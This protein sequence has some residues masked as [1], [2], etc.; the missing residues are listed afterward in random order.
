MSVLRFLIRVF[1][2]ISLAAAPLLAQEEGSGPF[3]AAERTP[4]DIAVGYTFLN[5]NVSGNPT[6]NLNG[7]GTSATINFHP[8][9]GATLDASYVRAGRDPGSG[10]SSYVL[11]VLTGPVFVATQ[12]DKT[13]VLVRVLGGVSVVDSAVRVND[14]YYRGYLSRFSWA[15]GSGIERSLTTSFAVRFNVD[16]LRTKFLNSD[17]AVQ[18]QNGIRVSANVVFR[19]SPRQTRHIAAGEP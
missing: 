15:V 3:P 10:H 11:S 5:M 1:I 7:I 19:F 13:R 9:W 17:L 12:N 16:Y 4:G 8:R 2:V 14:L 18:P 6:A